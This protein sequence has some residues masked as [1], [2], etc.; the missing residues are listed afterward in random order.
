VRHEV[1]DMNHYLD[2][3]SARRQANTILRLTVVTIVGLI[4]TVA[5]GLLGMNIIAEQ[6]KPV[7]ER[8]VVFLIAL[9]VTIILTGWSVVYSKR[10]ADVLD[11]LSDTRVGW[12]SKWSEVRRSWRDTR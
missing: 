11:A 2:S 1:T 6:D 8:I 4:G 10:L 5:S 12:L 7:T 9:V 3:D